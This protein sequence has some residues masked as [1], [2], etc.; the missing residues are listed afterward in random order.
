[1]MTRQQLLDMRKEILEDQDALPAALDMRQEEDQR[2]FAKLTGDYA[3]QL[4]IID[5]SLKA[6]DLLSRTV[7]SSASHSR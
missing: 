4:R 7:P 5:S 2:L 3:A 1:M 6:H